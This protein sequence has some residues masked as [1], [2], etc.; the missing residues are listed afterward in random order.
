MKLNLGLIIFLS[1]CFTFIALFTFGVFKPLSQQN[2]QFMTM[3]PPDRSVHIS[4]WG[5]KLYDMFMFLLTL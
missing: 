1:Y 2:I 3:Q 4:L 5:Y